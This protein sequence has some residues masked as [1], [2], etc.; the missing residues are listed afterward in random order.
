MSL[1]VETK[2]IKEKFKNKDY[3]VF[4]CM[5]MRVYDDLKLTNYNNFSISGE[6]PFLSEGNTYTL[7]IEEDLGNKFPCSYKVVSVPSLKT[8]L[9]DLTRE[10]SFE[11]LRE[12]STSDRL[13]NNILDAYSDFI[14]IILT[15]GKEAIDLS[16]INGVGEYYLSVFDRE[17]NSKYKYYAIIQK[18]K[19][20]NVNITDCKALFSEYE[21]EEIIEQKIKENPY[22]VLM[23]V[24]KRSFNATDKK[25]LEIKPELKDSR[26]RCE[27]LMIDILRRNEL[28]GN[29]MLNGNILWS[30]CREDYNCPIEWGKMIKDI[31]IESPY[32][33]Y[34]EETKNLANMDTYL[35][36]VQIANFVKEKLENSKS[37]N[38]DYTKYKVVDGFELTEQQL[39]TLKNANDYAFSLLVGYSGSGKTSSLKGLI[40]MLEDNHLTY[41]LL[42]PTGSASLRIE[43]QT[44]RK[45][46]TIHRK[47]LKDK[48]IWTDFLILDEMSMVDIPTFVMLLNCIKNEKMRVVLCGDNCQILPVGIGCLFND[49][50]NSNIAPITML[51]KIFRYDTSGG[52]FVATNIRKG[53]QFFNDNRVKKQGN[54][55]KISDN[56]R[57]IETDKEKIFDEVKKQYS[58]LIKKGIKQKD[59]LCLCPFNVGDCGNI[60]INNEI[61][62]EFNPPK[63]NEYTFEREMNGVKIIFRE[64]DRVINKKNDYEAMPLESYELIKN[65]ENNLITADD[66]EH[67][68]IFNG[69]KGV[70]RTVDDEK[71]VVQFDEEMIVFDKFKIKNLLL[72]YSQSTHSSQGSESDYVISVVNPSHKRMLNKNLLYVADTRAKKLHIDIGDV[73]TFNDSLLIDGNELRNTW[74]PSL[75]KKEN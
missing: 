26:I 8:E 51:D 46:S 1:I 14:N 47:C 23:N 19:D 70:I 13:C 53:K 28:D 31:A 68:Q 7:E 63:A 69:Q 37:L 60:R 3:R 5:P 20:Y 72:G 45:A 25:V 32:I 27:A 9:K 44:N 64:G 16:K 30:V 73:N 66:V 75:L 61:Q 6:L 17:L 34:D 36:E 11:I 49:I 10:E 42:A 74:L 50:I 59:I 54:I 56:Y 22:N 57:F 29:S 62:S 55:Y 41:T 48:E 71:M 15:E 38:I 21:K 40:Y 4:Y 58:N 24:L 67:T 35:G 52:A 43:E 33:Y 39:N 2:I 65:D 18:L 12:I